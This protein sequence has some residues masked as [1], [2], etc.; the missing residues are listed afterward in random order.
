VASQTPR[1]LTVLLNLTALAIATSLAG[2][3]INSDC[4]ISGRPIEAGQE[5][6][7]GSTT[8][9]FCCPKCPPA[10]ARWSDERKASWITRQ[11]EEPSDAPAMGDAPS[12]E[13]A[14]SPTGPYLLDICLITEKELGSM[15]EPAIAMIDGREVRFCCM[16]CKPK[17][18]KEKATYFKILDTKLATMQRRDYPL[19]TDVVDGAPLGEKPVEIVYDNRLFRF[20]SDTSA[21]AFNKNP[22]TF[23][24]IVDEAIIKAQL[25]LYP[26]TTCPIGKGP[27][28]GMGGPV[29]MIVGH[30]L[31]QLC[32]DSCRSGVLKDPLKV[33]KQLDEAAANAQRAE[34]PIDTCVVT[35]EKLDSMGGAVELT[36]GGRL[37]RFCC[38]GCFFL[39]D[40]SPGKHLAKLG[41]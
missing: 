1:S 29:N 16:P 36:A 31:I 25:P 17:F 18:E 24:P 20:G 28:D 41:T 14:G 39:F 6:T 23:I 26:M 8:V 5:V 33:I 4:P 27:L 37:V 2:E 35:G 13:Y 19:N 22:G 30:R 11:S 12:G 15:G 34:Y 10:F 7:V 9:G 3:P 21:E 32:C 38:A 40:A